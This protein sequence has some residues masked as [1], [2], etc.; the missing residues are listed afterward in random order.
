MR[1][2]SGWILSVNLSCPAFQI[3][4]DQDGFDKRYVGNAALDLR[5]KTKD[6]GFCA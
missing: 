3:S 6:C 4:A 2:G 5:Q 1:G